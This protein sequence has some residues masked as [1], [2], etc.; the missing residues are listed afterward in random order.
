MGPPARRGNPVSTRDRLAGTIERMPSDDARR[1]RGSCYCNAVRYAVRGPVKFVAHDHCS[2]CRRIAGA[3][4]VTWCGF[5]EDRFQLRAGSDALASFASTPDATR[6]FCRRCGSHLFFRSSRWPGEVHVTLASI[7]D[8][9]GL[10]PKAHVFA[11]DRAT[12]CAL[13][14]DGL[15]RL[16]GTSGTEPIA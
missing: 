1:W 11:S 15:P 14:D 13:P 16:G 6:G 5:R 4:F 9:K 8:P 2:I 10:V 3:A 7:H 12:W